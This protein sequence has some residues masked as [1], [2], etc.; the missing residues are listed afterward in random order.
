MDPIEMKL[1]D[2]HEPVRCI[3]RSGP[4][5]KVIASCGTKIVVMDTKICVAVENIFDTVEGR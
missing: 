2:P 5:R 3:M 4:D 1:G